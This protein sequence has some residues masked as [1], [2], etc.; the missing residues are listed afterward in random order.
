MFNLFETHWMRE[1]SE[2][3]MAFI[4]ALKSKSH[5][6]AERQKNHIQS[7]QTQ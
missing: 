4:E 1:F 5:S 3:G 2:W 7:L 6:G